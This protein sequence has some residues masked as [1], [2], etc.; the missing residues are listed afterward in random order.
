MIK[1]SDAIQ[2]AI[3]Q[4][5]FTHTHH[6]RFHTVDYI[7]PETKYA[8]MTN[9]QTLVGISHNALYRID[10]RLAG[11][12]LV[13]SQFKQYISK[14]DFSVVATTQKGHVAVASNKG[15]IRLFNEIGKNAKTKLPAL[16]DPIYGLDVTASGRFIVATC[17]TYLL[18]L[19]V[20]NKT[21]QKRRLGFEDDKPIPRRLQLKPEHVAYMQEPIN[22][23]PAR[24]NSG[25]NEETTIVTVSCIGL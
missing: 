14:N 6:R 9:T 17:S 4:H 18:F 19:D 10:P 22:F 2:V 13:D 21:D 23:T 7:S 3:S 20:E 24:F 8:Q 11:N 25:P 12:K 15:D 1:Y 16:G 5:Q